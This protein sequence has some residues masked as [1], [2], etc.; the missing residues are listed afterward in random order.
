MILTSKTIATLRTNINGLH[1]LNAE[2]IAEQIRQDSGNKV[3]TMRFEGEAFVL[4]LAR[5]PDGIHAGGWL[6]A[7]VRSGLTP[8]QI[9]DILEKHK[10]YLPPDVWPEL[11]TPTPDP[12]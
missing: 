9:M 12:R 11:G 10:P 2:Q 5:H 3:P 6:K 1:S 7:S 8:V 4:Y